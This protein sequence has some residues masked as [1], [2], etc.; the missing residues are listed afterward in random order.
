MPIIFNIY[1]LFQAIIGV[2]LLGLIQ[3]VLPLFGYNYD[4]IGGTKEA[5]ISLQILALIAAYLDAKGMKGSLFFLPTWLTLII[6]SIFVF[7]ITYDSDTFQ[8]NQFILYMSSIAI[9]AIYVKLNQRELRKKWKKRKHTLEMLQLKI[10]SNSITQ[11][12]YWKIAS[13]LL[14]NPSFFFLYLNPLWTKI[15]PNTI[16]AD[17]FL[18]YYKE[19]INTIDIDTIKNK[20]YNK[21]TRSLKESLNKPGTYSEYKHLTFSF[22]RLANTI[23]HMNSN[24]S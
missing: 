5:F 23:D 1:A 2:A 19:F 8:K 6:G 11:V 24:L 13:H 10:K 20:R 9:V 7:Y 3:L 12:E 21:W 14:Y 16:T 22:S 17:E 4:L 15:Y 18:Q